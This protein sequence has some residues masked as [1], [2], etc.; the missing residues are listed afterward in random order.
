MSLAQGN[1]TPTRRRIEHGSPDPESDAL[2]TRPVRPLEN[3]VLNLCLRQL[4]TNEQFNKASVKLLSLWNTCPYNGA[5]LMYTITLISDHKS[6]YLGT[7]SIIFSETIRIC[8]IN[9]PRLTLIN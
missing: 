4:T 3:I 7:L 6:D 2:T 1:N 8:S 9:D 5:L